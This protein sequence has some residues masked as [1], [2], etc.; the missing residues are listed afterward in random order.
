MTIF[1]TFFVQY[2]FENDESNFELIV[3]GKLDH[4]IAAKVKVKV[5][6]NG[7]EPDVRG[8]SFTVLIYYGLSVDHVLF[9]LKDRYKNGHDTVFRFKMRNDNDYFGIKEN[10]GE[11]F[12]KAELPKPIS[13]DGVWRQNLGI[14]V[15][16]AIRFKI[17][18]WQATVTVI[19]LPTYP[20]EGF[21]TRKMLDAVSKEISKDT[22]VFTDR[23][24]VSSKQ[25]NE[26]AS[27]FGLHRLFRRPS[28]QARSISKAKLFF[29]TVIQKIQDEV[30]R[31]FG[32][33]YYY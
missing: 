6:V 19:M 12:V 14:L 21:L 4:F 13:K 31:T 9:N 17:V 11:I 7:T 27:P 5:H 32:C 2:L 8:R 18:A 3:E 23:A 10:T 16:R 22:G 26:K 1:L 24:R 25:K 29:D 30:K 28:E 15:H 20:G 33:E